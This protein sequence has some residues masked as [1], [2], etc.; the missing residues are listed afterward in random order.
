M[1]HILPIL[2]NVRDSTCF[3]DGLAEQYS[4]L[5]VLEN[6]KQ[7][8]IIPHPD[9]YGRWSL[10]WHKH[11]FSFDTDLNPFLIF[12]PKQV[13]SQISPYLSVLK[14]A[15]QFGW[16]QKW[17]RPQARP[18][19]KLLE[20]WSARGT[21]LAIH[22]HVFFL[23]VKE[24]EFTMRC[25]ELVIPYFLDQTVLWKCH[26]TFGRGQVSGIIARQVNKFMAYYDKHE[27]SIELTRGAAFRL[28][29]I[30][31]SKE[32]YKCENHAGCSLFHFMA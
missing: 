7:K 26:A 28:F 20:S 14:A 16:R 13:Q 15:E 4:H 31:E 32:R 24:T 29:M 5:K 23:F 19:R 3:F 22:D 8:S 18:L 11:S 9:R 21:I 12:S 30:T 6:L 1:L 25:S 17:T 27:W 10:D 2:H